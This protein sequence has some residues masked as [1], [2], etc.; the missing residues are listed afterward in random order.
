MDKK[1]TARV[2]GFVGALGASALLL[3]AA[4][5]TT[6]AYFTDSHTG[7]LNAG[8]GHV[9]VDTTDLTLNFDN[10]LP[11]AYKTQRVDYTARGTD[12]EDIWM[13]FPNDAGQAEALVGAPDDGR[14]GGLGRYGHLKIASTG[15]A[16][17]VSNN[18]SNHVAGDPTSCN[19]D[20][21]GWGGSTAEAAS[22]ATLVPY[23]APANAILLQSGMNNGDG[24]HADVEFGFTKLLKGGQSGP[25]SKLATFKIVATQHGV[26]PDNVNNPAN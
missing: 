4:A 5:N 14:G 20:G 15:G 16:N 6:G 13:V 11:G 12:A 26:R 25:L 17:F 9:T 10:L 24:G 7:Q 19:I 3:G 8:T 18:L 23:C 22:T 2:A 21:N 1:K